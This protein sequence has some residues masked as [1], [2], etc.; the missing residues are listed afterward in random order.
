MSDEKA[1]M[2]EQ[3]NQSS[4]MPMLVT[5]DDLT[6]ALGSD[7]VE[8]MNMDKLLQNAL[9]QIR[10]LNREI[11]ASRAAVAT[12]AQHEQSAGLHAK[13]NEALAQAIEAER[14]KSA[15]L[16]RQLMDKERE[17]AEEL[18]AMKRQISTLKGQITKLKKG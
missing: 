11:V 5:N 7:R 4:G 8:L 12:A 10:L 1:P 2:N 14:G 13:K 16:G 18:A 17:H 9:G 15:R 6:M 3:P